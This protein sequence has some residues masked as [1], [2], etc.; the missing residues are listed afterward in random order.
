MARQIEIRVL[1]MF[2]KY[3][4]K[5]MQL[6]VGENI[7]INHYKKDMENKQIDSLR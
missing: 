2:E 5:S 3:G 4:F 1:S 7:S 6:L